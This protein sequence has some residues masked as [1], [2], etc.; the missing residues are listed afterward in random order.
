MAATRRIAPV[1]LAASL[2]GIFA[3]L[4]GCG[5][6]DA[7]RA[8]H[9]AR[10]QKYLAEEK[11]EK[12]RIEFA[13]ALQISPNDAEARFLSGRVAER[14]GNPRAAASMYQG[15]VDVNPEHVQARA[16]LAR[17]Y[18]FA[19]TPDMALELIK[20]GLDKHPDDPDLLTVRAG[21]RSQRQ[22]SAGALADAE[23]AVR[24]DPANEGAV[25][26]LAGLYQAAG[27]SPRAV[28]LLK[29]TLKHLP[30][31]VDLRQVLA[32]L[33]LSSGDSEGVEEQLLQVVQIKPS[34]LELR[35]QL[36]SFYVGAKRLDDAEHTLKA[37][38]LALP[39]SDEAKLIYADF[40]AT[41]RSPA[42]GEAA[43]REVIAHDP[44]N[45]DLQLGLGALQQ[46]AAT[47]QDAV[48]T[49]RAIIAKDANGAK[50][51]VAR[52][53]LAAIDTVAGHYT[54]ALPLLA[55][56]LKINPRDN[57]ALT[58]RGNIELERGDVGGAIADLRAVLR[59][60][61][62]AIPVLRSLARAHLANHD[63]ALAEENLRTALVAAPGDLGVRVDLG[64][65]L[66]ATHRAQEA[67]TLLEDTVRAAPGSA[68]TAARTVLVKAYLAKPDLPAARKAADDLKT[69]RPELSIGWYLAGLVAHRQ[70]RP[71]DAQREF[72]HALQ[73]QPSAPDALAALARLEAARGQ[74]SQAIALLRSAVART[75]G[76]AVTHNLLGELYLADKDYPEAVSTLNEA[77]R[78]APTWW[79]PYRNLA[80][81]KF[82]AKDEVG[83]LAA[84]EAGVKATEEPALV[85][86]LAAFYIHKGRV[87]DA[88][89]QYELLHEHSPRLELAANNLAMLLATYR[90]DQASL[91]RAR[92]LT[93]PF[94]NSDVGALLD[95]RGWVMFRR[96]ELPQAL[97]ALE[98]ASAAAPNSKV[99]LYHLGMAQLKA[100]Q[101]EKAR[102]SLEAAL[103]DG[104]S[105]KG[106][107]EARLALA[108]LGGRTG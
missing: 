93:A 30:H 88:I 19:G 78:L 39:K 55:E 87:D 40:L 10:G 100:G 92:D 105:F 47:T 1:L 11:L 2:L 67:I 17:L 83:G 46:R 108:Q 65:L 61:P 44:R 12:A 49:Y 89:R 69:L 82:A 8:S 42:R 86:D 28:E 74:R 38:I 45:L 106:T 60:Q 104:A 101:S 31:S 95:T 91:D 37:A 68:G 70:K 56:A 90:N 96:G 71:D 81:A 84:Y 34:E 48:A 9:I 53:R 6:A 58:M 51:V 59:D 64:E 4:S 16:N 97:S 54:E 23:H 52:D 80:V 72:E 57:D 107:D 62:S 43:L 99:I 20:P 27:Q 7:R 21:V 50:G 103:A 22:D 15:A 33:Y 75:P 41:Q 32:R 63:P 5:G 73:L 66:S 13:E 35:L 94:A 76:S 79:L 102:A 14:L 29:G 26:A 18:L 36:A 85:N 98:R 77:V 25:S 24:I 3:S